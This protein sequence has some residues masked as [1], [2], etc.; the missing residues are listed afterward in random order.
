MQRRERGGGEGEAIT[1]SKATFTSKERKINQNTEYS[2][3]AQSKGEKG[4]YIA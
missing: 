2:E 1:F 4:N 3:K